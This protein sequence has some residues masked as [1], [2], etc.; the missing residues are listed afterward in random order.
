VSDIG[1]RNLRVIDNWNMKNFS[2]SISGSHEMQITCKCL[3]QSI[4]LEEE[5]QAEMKKIFA[6]KEHCCLQ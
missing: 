1:L 6:Q 3:F 5:F 4:A 2:L